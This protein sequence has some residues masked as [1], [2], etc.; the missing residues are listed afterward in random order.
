MTSLYS[1]AIL[2]R[3]EIVEYKLHVSMFCATFGDS[4]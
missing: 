2:F 1:V 4:F 3:I